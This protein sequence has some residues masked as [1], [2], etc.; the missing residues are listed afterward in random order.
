MNL[1]FILIRYINLFTVHLTQA[2]NISQSI[3]TLNLKGCPSRDHIEKPAWDHKWF[4]IDLDNGQNQTT[5]QV[6]YTHH[7][8]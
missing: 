7:H 2:S 8:L 6:G 3:P 1:I 5:N 4:N